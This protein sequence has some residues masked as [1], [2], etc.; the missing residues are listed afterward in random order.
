MVGAAWIVYPFAD[1]RVNVAGTL[2]STGQSS[3]QHGKVPVNRQG[4][5]AANISTIEDSA[6]FSNLSKYGLA[7]RRQSS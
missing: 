5:T 4:P 1:V 6:A 7:Q 3:D 2:G